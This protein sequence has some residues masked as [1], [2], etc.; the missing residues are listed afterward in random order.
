MTKKILAV[1][2]SVVLC[3]VCSAPV[4]AAGEL[5]SGG[6]DL[7]GMLGDVAGGGS[8]DIES[9]LASD[10][11]QEILAT[12]GVT[13][14]TDV[15]IDVIA[16]A[17]SIDIQGMGKDKATALVQ[18]VIDLVGGEL[19]DTATNIDAFATNPLDIVDRLFD[20]DVKDTIEDAV[21]KP[22]NDDNDLV[23]TIGDVDGDGII[24]P[25]DARLALRKAA[26]LIDLTDEQAYRADIDGDGTVTHKDARIILRIAADL[27]ALDSYVK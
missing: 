2:M 20:T 1:I 13:D 17:G 12:Q 21:D 4:F 6:I 24:T 14:I 25:A 15:V 18:N 16:N 5:S 19:K 3:A 22:E 11:A 9:I 8:L 26:S 10:I 27:E 7:E 23:L